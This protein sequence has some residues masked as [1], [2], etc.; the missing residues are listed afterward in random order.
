MVTALAWNVVCTE[1][2]RE[3]TAARHLTRNG[4]VAYLPRMP[5]SR[6][7][8][9]PLFPN[10][11]FVRAEEKHRRRMRL[12]IPRFMALRIGDVVRSLAEPMDVEFLIQK[13]PGI[14]DL[15]RIGDRPAMLHDTSIFHIRAFE[16]E[17]FER[18]FA[19]FKAG[20][21]V[22]TSTR[23]GPWS[24]LQG[25]VCRVDKRDRVVINVILPSRELTVCLPATWLEPA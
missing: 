12:L 15:L 2:N 8:V 10:Y 7:R 13:M 9:A 25:V 3:E 22:R 6:R 18:A 11:L 24:D 14:R 21:R 17:L 20:D 16:R 5:V 4:L 19:P 23:A 1:S